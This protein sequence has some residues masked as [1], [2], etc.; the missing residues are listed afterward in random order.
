MDGQDDLAPA[1][2]G[3]PPPPP[4]GP[5]GPPHVPVV[6]PLDDMGSIGAAVNAITNDKAP[7]ISILESMAARMNNLAMENRLTKQENLQLLTAARKAQVA[8]T[9]AKLTNPMSIRAVTNNY[10]LQHMIEDILST[11]K[12]NGQICVPV[13]LDRATAIIEAQV[14]LLEEMSRLL[15]RDN[16]VHQIAKDSHIGWALLPYLDEEETASEEKDSLKLIKSKD[17]STA[18]KNFMSFNLDKSKTSTFNRGAG[19]RGGASTRGKGKNKGKGRQKG[20][21]TLNQVSGGSVGKSNKPRSG[22]CHR[23][24]GPHFVRSC[25]VAVQKPAN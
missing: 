20:K 11:L 13:S 4:P 14:V 25:T 7:I 17:I 19:G 18:E 21:S 3:G 6:E 9:L 22:G 5:P 24:G 15:Q 10:K 2:V 12:S 23:C 16:E 8:S 1:P